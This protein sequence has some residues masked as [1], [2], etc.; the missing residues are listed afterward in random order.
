MEAW[1]YF[2]V[3]AELHVHM[4]IDKAPHE[5]TH[6]SKFLQAQQDREIRP[7]LAR[8]NVTRA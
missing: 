1:E 4:P 6:F 8:Y 3:A 2:Q 5:T 7:C